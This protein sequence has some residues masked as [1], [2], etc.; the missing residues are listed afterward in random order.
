VKVFHFL[1]NF[2]VVVIV[3]TLG[4]ALGMFYWGQDTPDLQG[5]A[6]VGRT[7]GAAHPMLTSPQALEIA[8]SAIKGSAE[9][10]KPGDIVVEFIQSKYRVRFFFVVSSERLLDHLLEV[11]VDPESRLAGKV[12]DKGRVA[13]LQQRSAE[14]GWETFLSGKRAFDLSV[15]ALKGFDN[16]DKQGKLSIELR[17][18]TYYVTFPVPHN[19]QP[20]PLAAA[21]A[22]QIWVDARSGKVLKVL[23]AS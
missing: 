9:R 1:L 21:Y 3:S 13:G 4:M 19:E 14:G 18:S 12:E 2:S 7:H 16:Y 15:E 23:V 11:S 22:V 17:K 8:Y 5:S 6:A 10:E 20:Q